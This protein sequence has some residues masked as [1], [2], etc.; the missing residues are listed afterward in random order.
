VIFDPDNKLIP[1]RVVS[2]DFTVSKRDNLSDKR[3]KA[4]TTYKL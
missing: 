1:Y 4:K 2:I 3:K